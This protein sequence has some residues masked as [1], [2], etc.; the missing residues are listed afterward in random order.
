M[1]QQAASMMQNNPG[2]AQQARWAGWDR[3][4]ALT[5]RQAGPVSGA[6]SP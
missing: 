1:Q 6:C 3:A 2:M 4:H 5:L